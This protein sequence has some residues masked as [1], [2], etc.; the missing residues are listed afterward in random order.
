M[1][2]ILQDLFH[3]IYLFY[4]HGTARNG[5][6]RTTNQTTHAV[7]FPLEGHDAAALANLSCDDFGVVVGEVEFAEPIRC[8]HAV[9]R[10]CHLVLTEFELGVEAAGVDVRGFVCTRACGERDPTNRR[11]EGELSSR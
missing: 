5:D 4:A 3:P 11:E 7:P 6:G 1:Y 8:D 9:C 10:A 2:R